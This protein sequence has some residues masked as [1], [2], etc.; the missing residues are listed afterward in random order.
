MSHIIRNVLLFLPSPF[1]KAKMQRTL[2][3]SYGFGIAPSVIS[4]TWRQYP[5][6]ICKHERDRAPHH[7]R[8]ATPKDD[9][10]ATAC[11]NAESTS[12]EWNGLHTRMDRDHTIG[13][14]KC[15]IP[16]THPPVQSPTC[17]WSRVFFLSRRRPCPGGGWWVPANQHRFSR[18]QLPA[19]CGPLGGES[20]KADC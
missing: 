4:S 20:L 11:S 2:V 13:P 14:L 9:G 15:Q 5:R 10:D 3:T 6:V 7:H 16:P 18:Q 8:V 12:Q 1:H 17:T 19:G